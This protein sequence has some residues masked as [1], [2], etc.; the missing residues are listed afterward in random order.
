MYLDKL[1]NINIRA[2]IMM[3]PALKTMNMN[4]FTTVANDWHIAIIAKVASLLTHTAGVVTIKAAYKG[5]LV[6]VLVACYESYTFSVLD[7]VHIGSGGG[8]DSEVFGISCCSI[9]QYCIWNRCYSFLGESVR[10]RQ[11]IRSCGSFPIE[12]V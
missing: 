1:L 7:R 5:P 9:G 3:V 4:G 10:D 12:T 11:S 6:N 2:S 8:H